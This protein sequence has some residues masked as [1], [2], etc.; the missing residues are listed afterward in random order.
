MAS[1]AYNFFTGPLKGSH[2]RPAKSCLD[3]LEAKHSKGTGMYWFQISNTGTPTQGYCDMDAD[4][5][6]VTLYNL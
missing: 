3:I 2:E 5:G 1:Y 4:G 6:E